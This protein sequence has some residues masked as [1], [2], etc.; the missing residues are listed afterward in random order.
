MVL[1]SLLSCFWQGPPVYQAGNSPQMISA[2]AGEFFTIDCRV[3]ESY[4]TDFTITLK[5]PGDSDGRN[6]TSMPVGNFSQ[7]QVGNYMYECRADNTRITTSLIY[8]VQVTMAPSKW[9]HRLLLVLL[10][11]ISHYLANP[12]TIVTT[13]PTPTRQP[14]CEEINLS[15]P[16]I[17]FNTLIFLPN[18][19]FPNWCYYWDSGWSSSSSLCSQSTGTCADLLLSWCWCVCCFWVCKEEENKRWNWIKF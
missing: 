8:Q 19:A 16:W 15:V 11:G 14:S 17:V 10:N 2:I 13:T 12:S 4:P 1:I 9:Y 6:I 5:V 18:S 7:S 3:V